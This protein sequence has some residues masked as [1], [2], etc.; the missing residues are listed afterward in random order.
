[1]NQDYPDG[2]ARSSISLTDGAVPATAA[3][4]PS[5]A[6]ARTP[7]SETTTP[8]LRA[9][10]AE[11]ALRFGMRALEVQRPGLAFLKVDAENAVALITYLKQLGGYTH[12]SFFTAVDHIEEGAFDLLYMLHCYGANQDLG[13]T[14]RIPRLGPD[15]TAPTMDGIHH[16]WPAAATYQQELREMFGIEFPGSPGL[17]EDFALEGWQDLP[18][19]RRDFDT[20]EYSERT[21]YARPGRTT[22]DPRTHMKETIYP[23]EAETW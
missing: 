11:L 9:L 12:L 3:H 22:H 13:V 5:P 19:M 18:P 20:K 10:G 14:V 6:A 1:M 15:N 4:S 8:D 2:A 7:P 23:S 16:L 17:H 21:Y